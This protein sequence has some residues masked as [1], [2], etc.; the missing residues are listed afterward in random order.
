MADQL[1]GE[2]I[3]LTYEDFCALPDDGKR[4]EI[5]NGDLYMSPSP[6]IPHQ[7][8]IINLAAIIH[9]YV[10]KHKLGTVL[11]APTDVLLSNH[12]IVEPD[13]LFV[14]KENQSII[15]HKHIKGTP[16]LITEVLSPS[17]SRRDLRL[18]RDLYARSSVPFYW[19]LDP[20]GPRVIELQLMDGEYA[21]VRE[22]EGDAIFEPVIFP[23][24][25]ISMLEL[26]E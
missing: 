25:K 12:D 1:V 6:N 26:L 2:P 13:I 10:R 20:D 14:S 21:V 7:K 9:G 18:K 5:I 23:G 17:T 24:L 19:I 4:Y 11:V 3:H 8:I 15:T 22:L 16:D